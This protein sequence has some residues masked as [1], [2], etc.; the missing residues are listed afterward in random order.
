MADLSSSMR[1]S[2]NDV[3]TPAQPRGT[4][5]PFVDVLAQLAK[6]PND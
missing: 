5:K 3:P 4:A 2:S 6:D 1:V